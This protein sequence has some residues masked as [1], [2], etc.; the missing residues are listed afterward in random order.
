MRQSIFG[1]VAMLTLTAPASAQQ[2]NAEGAARTASVTSAIVQ[3][4]GPYYLVDGPKAA[5]LSAAS[6]E[7][8]LQ[9]AAPGKGKALVTAEFR[10]RL[11]EVEAT[12][13]SHWCQ[14]I[15]EVHRNLGT[16]LFLN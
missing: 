4:C 12:G 6:R 7:L 5:K 16:G 8:A 11:K 10:R 3:F 13:A 1:M 15:R 2:M 14:N 9:W